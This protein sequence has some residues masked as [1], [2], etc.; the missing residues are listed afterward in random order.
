[1]PHEPAKQL[2]AD[3]TNFAR[4]YRILISPFYKMLLGIFLFIV[5]S[6]INLPLSMCKRVFLGK[7][8]NKHKNTVCTH[9]GNRKN[10][11][12]FKISF[13]FHVIYIIKC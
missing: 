9:Q 3:L 13:C 1:M 5:K 7:Q 6:C 10:N 2:P 4:W 11:F 12:F 8:T